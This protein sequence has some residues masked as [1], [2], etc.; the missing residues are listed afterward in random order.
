[1]PLVTICTRRLISLKIE[2]IDSWNTCTLKIH[3]PRP[4]QCHG[5]IQILPPP[6]PWTRSQGQIHPI[7]LNSKR[8]LATQNLASP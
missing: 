5:L 8:L 2:I 3:N 6:Q 4:Y 1:M 7:R